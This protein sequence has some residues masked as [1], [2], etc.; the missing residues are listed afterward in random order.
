MALVMRLTT[1]ERMEADGVVSKIHVAANKPVGP[2]G[3]H[4]KAMTEEADGTGL[5]SAA[6][7]DDRPDRMGVQVR[8]PSRREWPPRRRRLNP[9]GS[10]LAVRVDIASRTFL[11]GGERHVVEASPDFSLP[12]AADIFDGRLKSTLLRRR[13]H[14]NDPEPQAVDT[15][16]LRALAPLPRA[17]VP[18]PSRPQPRTPQP[19]WSRWHRAQP[20]GAPTEPPRSEGPG[21]G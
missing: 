4:R 8:P 17:P 7:E 2:K 16:A 3:V 14:R 15:N 12:A 10:A 1:A 6:D 11:E 21:S 9:G 13:E 20:R 19:R 5:R 18:R